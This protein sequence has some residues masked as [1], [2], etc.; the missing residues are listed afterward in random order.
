MPSTGTPKWRLYTRL[1]ELGCNISVNNAGMENRREINLSKVVCIS[2][3]YHNPHSSV[4]VNTTA[5]HT[6][7]FVT[8]R[9]EVMPSPGSFS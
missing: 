7:V 3:A 5:H 2:I 9:P 1:Y 4:K 6:L 8:A